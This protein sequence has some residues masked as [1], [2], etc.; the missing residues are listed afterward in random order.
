V[1]CFLFGGERGKKLVKGECH[2]WGGKQTTAGNAARGGEGTADVYAANKRTRSGPRRRPVAE[3]LV[4]MMANGKGHTGTKGDEILMVKK[5][6]VL[7]RGKL[8]KSC[9]EVYQKLRPHNLHPKGRG[10]IFRRRRRLKERDEGD[11]SR[12]RG[13]V[14]YRKG[15]A[16]GKGVALSQDRKNL[17]AK[18][19]ARKTRGTK[20][21]ERR[22]PSQRPPASR[23]E[24]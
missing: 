5:K 24:R 15:E 9:C 11:K 2:Q 16:V 22:A 3:Q 23:W 14:V 6:S 13:R 17:L 19:C 8:I 12:P 4:I 20:A 7:K 1:Q 18:M 10:P 21:H